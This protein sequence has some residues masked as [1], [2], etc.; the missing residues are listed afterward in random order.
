MPLSGFF[1]GAN[2]VHWPPLTGVR[3]RRLPCRTFPLFF[4]AGLFFAS[5]CSDFWSRQQRSDDLVGLN[6]RGVGLM[7]QFNYDEAREIFARLSAAHPD[8]IDL[9]INLAIATLNRQRE[10]DADEA[11]RILERVAGVDS[12]NL[13]AR[14]GLGLVLLNEGHTAEAL[15]QFAY[16]VDRDPTDAFATYYLARCR[17][18]LGEFAAALAGYQRALELDPHLR[19]AAYGASQALQRL[20]RTEQAQQQLDAFRQ[21]E[22]DPRSEVVEFKYTRMGPLAEA[23]TIDQP[24]VPA[25]NRPAGPVFDPTPIA[26][27]PAGTAWRRFDASH[28]ASITAADIDGDGQVDIFIAAAIEDGGGTRNAVLF[29]RG[30]AG[31]V[32]DTSHPLAAVT[33]VTTALWGDFDN[34]GLTDVYLCR[35][36]ANQLWRQTAKGQWSNVTASAHADGGGGTTID[37]A[38][39]DADHDGDL[40]LLLIKRDAAD[41]LLNN[42][43]D[44][45]FRSIASTIGLTDTLPSTGLVVADLDADRDADLILIKQAAPP[46]TLINDRTWQYHRDPRFGA[47]ANA[48]VKAAVAGDLDS[49]GRVEIYTSGAGGIARW[50]RASSGEWASSAVRGSEA[51]AASA[52]LALS[53]LDGDGWLDLV[54]S[55]P[56][57]RVQAI[58]MSSGGGAPL[59]VEHDHP[60]AAWTLALLDPTRGPSLV[61]VP[62]GPVVRRSSGVRERGASR[63]LP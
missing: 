33:A 49:N 60:L 32:L 7:G 9:Q 11:R 30:A 4:A 12:G 23:A 57:G 24:R 1:V 38:L 5:G 3:R 27:G 56:D 28:P 59:F 62:E 13:R 41:E 19:S 29:N 63:L 44:G 34:D 43:G 54:G 6:N 39:F 53:D 58:A 61:G 22:T 8:R 51:L 18:E 40:D 31:F 20:G 15:P 47:A 37:G 35:Q 52:Q 16:V 45:T 26:L 50:T 36:G 10:G 55:G 14:Y 48:T 42:N 25:P 17:F 21:L 2:R 46:T